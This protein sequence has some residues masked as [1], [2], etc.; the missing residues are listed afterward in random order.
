MCDVRCTAVYH[1]ECRG[2]WHRW[3]C[4]TVGVWHCGIGGM[5]NDCLRS[6]RECTACAEYV[7]RVRFRCL[8]NLIRGVFKYSTNAPDGC[9]RWLL[10]YR[11]SLSSVMA[12]S[13]QGLRGNLW[14][15]FSAFIKEALKVA[16]RAVHMA[17][18]GNYFLNAPGKPV[19][20]LSISRSYPGLMTA[21]SIIGYL[22]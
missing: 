3:H 10:Q 11:K 6:V 7:T 2:V 12:L 13:V 14:V 17:H 18:H 16:Q 21:L 15:R 9:P 8:A 1:G 20:F 22:I 4:S 5:S 19:V